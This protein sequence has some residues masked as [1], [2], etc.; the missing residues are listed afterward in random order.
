MLEEAI[1]CPGCS[2][3]VETAWMR[4]PGWRGRDRGRDTE[5]GREISEI[6][7]I[8]IEREQKGRASQPDRWMD[9]WMDGWIDGW[10][11]RWMDG[12]KEGRKDR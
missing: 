12:R 7:E 1:V 4:L 2:V 9:G 8:E 5:V 3:K 6:D 10:I 11:D